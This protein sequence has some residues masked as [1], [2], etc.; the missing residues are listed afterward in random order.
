MIDTESAHC[1][2]LGPA[3]QPGGWCWDPA[4]GFH[5]TGP[6]PSAPDPT[7][8]PQPSAQA[9]PPP[10]PN[11]Q[12][13]QAAGWYFA[14]VVA[15]TLDGRRRLAQLETS[16]DAG[17]V[18]VLSDRAARLRQTSVRLASVRV[19]PLSESAAEV[20]LRL[21]TPHLSYAAALRLTRQRGTWRCTD[22]VMG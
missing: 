7:P 11:Q 18:Q 12:L 3:A 16:F 22:L 9:P 1:T 4:V 2:L 17:S 19:Q 20:A 6:E 21:A 14:K 10:D 15:E 8:V 5:V 13:L